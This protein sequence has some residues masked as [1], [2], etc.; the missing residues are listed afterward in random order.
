MGETAALIYTVGMSPYMPTGFFSQGS[1]LAVLM[2]SLISEGA[3]VGQSYAVGSMLIIFVLVLNLLLAWIEH[4]FKRERGEKGF[5]RRLKDRFT[6][7]GGSSEG[8]ESGDDETDE[9]K[10]IPG[11]I[12]NGGEDILNP[13][14]SMEDR[15]KDE[16]ILE[17]TPEYD[18]LKEGAP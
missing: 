3:S 11:P 13:S 12:R 8:G 4:M 17:L 9:T 18:A 1:S 7:G 14:N 16:P 15:T 5:F 6:K 10:D 2:Y